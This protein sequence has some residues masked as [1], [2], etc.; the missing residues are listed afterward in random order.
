MLSEIASRFPMIWL[1]CIALLMFFGL[2][3]AILA[4]V[5]R[6]GSTEVYG[7]MAKAPFMNSDLEP[8]AP[9]H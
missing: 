1:S 5:Y 7:H 6:K 9:N 8:A 3:L 2:F 4:W